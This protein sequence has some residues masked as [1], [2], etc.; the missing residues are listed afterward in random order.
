MSTRNANE[1]ETIMSRE[2]EDGIEA[3]LPLMPATGDDIWIR[4][5]AE[6]IAAAYLRERTDLVEKEAVE[7]FLSD[8]FRGL[9]YV[10]AAFREEFSPSPSPTDRG[11]E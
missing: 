6:R 2:H 7:Q 3:L 5:R 1:W 8:R 4:E 11:S 10:A 9:P